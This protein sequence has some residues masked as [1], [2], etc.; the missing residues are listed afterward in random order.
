MCVEKDL[1]GYVTHV[2]NIFNYYMMLQTYLL[3][4]VPYLEHFY[5][6]EQKVKFNIGVIFLL[7]GQLLKV[8]FFG[9]FHT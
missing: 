3:V 5:F 1:L 2:F 9:E 4:Y 7:Y 6:L 8:N